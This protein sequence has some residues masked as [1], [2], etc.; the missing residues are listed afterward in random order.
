MQKYTLLICS[1]CALAVLGIGLSSCKDDEPYVKPNLTVSNATLTVAEGAGTVQVEFVLDKGAPENFTIEYSLTGTAIS[2]ADY[3]IV[4]KEGEVEIASGG[5]SATVQIQIVSDAIYEGNETIEISIE[6]VSSDNIVVTNNDET[7]V[8]ITDD[9]PQIQLS[10]AVAAVT[11]N[12]DDEEVV[13]EINLSNPAAQAVTVGYTLTGTAQDAAAGAAANPAVPPQLWDYGIDSETTGELVIPQGA[14]KGE[15]P[16]L[17]ATDFQFEDDETIIITLN[18]AS[19]GVQIGANKTTTI[20][21]KQQNGKVIALVWDNT[22]ADVDMD[23]FLW[24][25]GV[26]PDE[27]LDFSVNAGTDPKVEAL[28]V[29]SIIQTGTLGC[30]YVYYS[31]TK[32][33]MNFEVHFAD[34]ANGVVEPAAN[35]D[36]FPGTYTL[37]NINAWDAE[38]APSPAIAQTFQLVAGQV[39]NIS[40]PIVIPATGSRKETLTL[41]KGIKKMKSSSAITYKRFQ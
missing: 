7:E 11:K 16:V 29:P 17:I 2:P 31:G 30:S 40:T 3:T 33:P 12:E 38:G 13:V 6:D 24:N 34:F 21:L 10:M 9:D 1:L 18:D 32:T 36:V 19:N 14:T 27:F 4:G 5:T 39:S 26:D 25:T 15:I 28:F 35:R 23:M 37:A 20:T 22:Y 8:T 41:P